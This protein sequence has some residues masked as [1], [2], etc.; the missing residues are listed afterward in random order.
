MFNN[1]KFNWP[2]GLHLWS[3][4]NNNINNNNNNI[5]DDTYVRLGL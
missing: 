3:I 2:A 5:M 1:S 4:I